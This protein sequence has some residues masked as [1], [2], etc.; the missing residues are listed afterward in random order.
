MKKFVL[1]FISL[2]FP[3]S[4]FAQTKPIGF[5]TPSGNITCVQWSEGSGIRCDLGV[6]EKISL[7][8]PKDCYQVWGQAFSLEPQG[9][10]K[11]ECVGDSI[12]AIQVPELPYGQVWQKNGFSCSAEKVGL[13]CTN[14]EGHGFSLSKK[15]QS[16]F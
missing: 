6:T 5:K 4:L 13:R 7:P 11:P 8:K 3:I 12:G 2:I 1:I 14:T 10:A 16:L 15:K 9:K